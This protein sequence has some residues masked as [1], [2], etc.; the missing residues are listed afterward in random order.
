MTKKIIFLLLSLIS[1]FSFAQKN[2]FNLSGT[3]EDTESNMLPG[4]NIRLTNTNYGTAADKN[5]HFEFKK[6]N[7]GL[8]TI[9][10]SY[11]GYETMLKDIE[12]NKNLEIKIHL[13]TSSIITEEVIVKATRAGTNTPMAYQN[14]KSDELKTINVGQDLPVLLDL[15]P[16][17]VTTTDAGAGVGYTGIRVRGSDATRV[18]VT[19]NGIPVNDAESHGVWWVNMPDITSSVQDIQIQRGV[20]TSTNGAGAF[21]ASINLQTEH[22]KNKPFA[23]IDLSGGSFNTNKETIKFGTGN[24]DNGFSFSGRVSSIM[25]DG[26]ID[27]ASSDL[28]SYFLNGSYKTEKS[29]IKLIGFGGRER[30]Y[31]SWNGIDPYT[32]AEDRTFNSA[33][34][35]YHE[36]GEITY[37]DDEVDNYQQHHI[38]LLMS[39]QFNAHWTGNLNFHYTRGL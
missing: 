10:V 38:Q 34:A 19:I 24:M 3:I 23:A 33:G 8:Y 17:V 6:L 25:S 12:L 36:N 31:Q 5:G 16:S 18:N 13:K 4:A 1:V 15:T 37:Y 26:Y 35:I 9:E 32:M 30:T 28:K 20:G 2:Q 39:H 29:I 27:R 21:G 22:F 11:L 7:E 14:I